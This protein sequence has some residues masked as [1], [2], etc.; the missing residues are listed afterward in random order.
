MTLWFGLG[1]LAA[2]GAEAIWRGRADPPSIF[3]VAL[4]IAIAVGS[5]RSRSKIQKRDEPIGETI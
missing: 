1:Y 4:G 5:A 2:A 3:T